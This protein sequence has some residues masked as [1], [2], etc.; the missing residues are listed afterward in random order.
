MGIACAFHGRHFFRDIEREAVCGADSHTGRFQT[1]VDPIHAVI[2]FDDF[3]HFR[4]PLRG[5]PG[6]GGDTCFTAHTEIVVNENNAVLLA[7]LH[8]TGGA[9]RDTPG[10]FTVKTGHEN[11]GRPGFVV[12]EFGSHLDDLA[13]PGLGWK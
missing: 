11:K 9:C 12:K 5:T 7:A 10:I 8:G 13:G 1:L 3:S 4:S 2:T 6:T